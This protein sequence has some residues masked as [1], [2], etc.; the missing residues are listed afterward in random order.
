MI[1][2]RMRVLAAT[3]GVFLALVAATLACASM[4]TNTWPKAVAGSDDRDCAHASNSADPFAGSVG[5]SRRI[6]TPCTDVVI[7]IDTSL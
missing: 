2:R 3:R 4:S 1:D 5:L 6:D 7:A